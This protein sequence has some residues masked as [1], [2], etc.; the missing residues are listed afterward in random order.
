MNLR[1]SCRYLSS[2]FSY[3]EQRTET[4]VRRG[5]NRFRRFN[6]EVMIP[7]P[8]K[9]RIKWNIRNHLL[10]ISPSSTK[11]LLLFIPIVTPFQL[12][13]YGRIEIDSKATPFVMTIC[14]TFR[15]SFP[16]DVWF[17][18][19]CWRRLMFKNG[20]FCLPYLVCDKSVD[21]TW[22]LLI[23]KLWIL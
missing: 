23:H 10:T 11:V 19:D 16:F 18:C 5:Q 20:C 17:E 7:F 4:D 9:I 22:Q 1:E 6:L 15:I 8:F 21:A 13:L 14:V 2:I 12:G 3:I